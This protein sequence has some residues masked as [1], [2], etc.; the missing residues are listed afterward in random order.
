MKKKFTAQDLYDFLHDLKTEFAY[1]L[2]TLNVNFRENGDSD[3]YAVN[4][5][6][7]DLYDAETNSVLTS[8]MLFDSIEDSLY[9][10]ID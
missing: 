6:F 2:S 10:E 1:D 5:V 9:E 4:Y 7:E 8:I 3:V